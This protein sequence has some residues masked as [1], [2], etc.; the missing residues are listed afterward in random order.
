MQIFLNVKTTDDMNTLRDELSITDPD[1]LQKIVFVRGLDNVQPVGNNNNN[2]VPIARPVM[3][4]TK[5]IETMGENPKFNILGFKRSEK[6]KDVIAALDN[7]HSQI[8]EFSKDIEKE[9][10]NLG[11]YNKHKA[12]IDELVKDLNNKIDLYISGSNTQDSATEKNLK[13]EAMEVLQDELFNIQRNSSNADMDRIRENFW[14]KTYSPMKDDQIDDTAQEIVL[15]EG[16]QGEVKTVTYKGPPRFVAA[17]KIDSP[18][19]SNMPSRDAGIPKETHEQSKRAVA[20]FAVNNMLNMNVIPETRFVVTTNKKDGKIEFGQAMQMVNGII[21]QRTVKETKIPDETVKS[22]GMNPADMEL[23]PSQKYYPNTD[24]P[25]EIG[26]VWT[27]RREAPDNVDLSL[28]VV[29]KDLSELQLLDN[30]IGHADRHGENFIFV[31][32]P[33]SNNVIGIKGIDND[34][35]FGNNWTDI[36]NPDELGKSSKTPGLPPVIDMN[37]AIKI[38]NLN[39]FKAFADMKKELKNNLPQ[40]DIDAA[41]MRLLKVQSDLKTKIGNGTIKV[42]TSSDQILDSQI[43]AMEFAIGSELQ[44]PLKN[45]VLKWGPQTENLHTENNSYLGITKKAQPEN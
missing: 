10:D 30:I 17:L 28:A 12:K 11:L 29:Q 31:T 41:I 26:E 20:S 1:L 16:A 18:E 15:G 36:Q 5:L 4:S 40:D 23:S 35:T 43:N 42:A 19:K 24:N 9:G 38:L 21:G 34:D 44:N 6:Y 8:D 13:K 2:A 32:A 27:V 45:N 39:P 25:A 22:W 3:D 14:F 37:T 7:Y 33:N